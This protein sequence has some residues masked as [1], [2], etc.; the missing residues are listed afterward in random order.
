MI[1]FPCTH[2]SQTLK[3]KDASVGQKGKCPHCGQA[4]RVPEKSSLTTSPA[5]AAMPHQPAWRW[6]VAVVT[7][8]VL[9]VIGLGGLAAVIIYRQS[10]NQAVPALVSDDPDVQVVVKNGGQVVATPSPQ[11]LSPAAGERGRGEGVT[12][13]TG[14]VPDKTALLSYDPPP[15]NETKPVLSQ[16]QYDECGRRRDFDQLMAEAQ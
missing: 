7:A 12:L 3:V 5:V 16:S 13:P 9:A 8:L 11:P 1:S 6:P 10:A 14:Q 2:C 15:A 4:I